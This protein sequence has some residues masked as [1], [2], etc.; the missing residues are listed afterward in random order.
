[1]ADPDPAK[2]AAAQA[3]FAKTKGN[4]SKRHQQRG[5]GQRQHLPGLGVVLA[6]QPPHH[7][8]PLL[9][10]P[11][12]TAVEPG[13]GHRPVGRDEVGHRRRARLQGD[14]PGSTGQPA[15]TARRVGGQPVHHAQLRQG[16]AV[17]PDGARG[18][19]VPRALRAD[20]DPVRERDER[21]P[22]QPDGQDLQTSR[23]WTSWPRSAT[24][25]TR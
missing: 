2:Q 1:M 18:R 20:R 22:E 10:G 24:R 23:T 25:T 6:G 4:L 5:Q 19:S 14:R 13:Q 7:L 21:Q 17:L 16:A 9:G 3:S 8:Q 15:G 11:G 12:G